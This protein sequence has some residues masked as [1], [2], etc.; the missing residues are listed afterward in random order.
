[1]FTYDDFRSNE[2]LRT[3]LREFLQSDIG[4]I[5]LR[6]LRDKFRATDVPS[7]VDALASARVL[8]QL[9]GAQSVLDDLENLCMPP[10]LDQR[11]V[12]LTYGAP[13]TD[14]EQ[15]PSDAE[16]KPQ[17]RVPAPVLPEE[18]PHA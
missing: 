10:G 17:V 16:L 14:H 8:S 4:M 5:L 13:E 9:H 11:E 7:T 1:M 6:V 12:P 18:P 15:M 2:E 3:S